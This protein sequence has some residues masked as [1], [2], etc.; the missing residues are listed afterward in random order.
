M[1]EQKPTSFFRFE[2]LRVYHKSLD[3]YNW[4]MEQVRQANELDRKTILLPLLDTAAKIATQPSQLVV[5][6]SIIL[7]KSPQE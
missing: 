1:E 7:Y 5:N 3:Y 2:D 6:H 4:L